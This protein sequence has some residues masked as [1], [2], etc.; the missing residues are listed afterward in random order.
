[1]KINKRYGKYNCFG[2]IKSIIL[3]HINTNIKDYLTLSIVFIIGVMAG[4]VLINNSNEKSKSEISGY[5]NGFI[6]SIKEEK[7]EVDKGKLVKMSIVDNMKTVGIIWLAGT[8]IIGIPLIYIIIAYKGFCMGYT[9]SAIISSL[10][11][12]KRNSFFISINVF[13]KYNNNS[14]CSYV[15]CKCIKVI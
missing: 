11:I 13:A 2:E 7:Y 8:T 1:M 14:C 9:I 6:S 10:G 3:Q 5:V 15:K 4:V 12:W